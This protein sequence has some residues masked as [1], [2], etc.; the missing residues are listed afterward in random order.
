MPPLLSAQGLA[1]G[2]SCV[3]PSVPAGTPHFSL[4]LS[5]IDGEDDEVG[6]F[7]REG[8]EREAPDGRSEEAAEMWQLADELEEA[9]DR[10]GHEGEAWIRPSPPRS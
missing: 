5:A 4:V 8:P 6:G 3:P 7:R 9:G 10:A 1:T 2:T